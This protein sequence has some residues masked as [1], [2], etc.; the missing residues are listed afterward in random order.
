[1]ECM[2]KVLF[3]FSFNC[4]NVPASDTW[5]SSALWPHS[6]LGWPD[7]TPELSYYYPTSALITSRDIIS[8]WV[9][10][11]VLAGYY[12]TGKKPFQQVFIHPKIL[13]K[14]GEGIHH[15]AFNVDD[16]DTVIEQLKKEFG[17]VVEQEGNYGDGTGRYIYLDCQKELKCRIE[18]LESFK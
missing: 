11:M 6:T 15:I 17:A 2:S 14:Y 3:V 8:L 12:N 1:M 16:A 9:A 5:F 4:H 18:L 13:D 7:E 10:R